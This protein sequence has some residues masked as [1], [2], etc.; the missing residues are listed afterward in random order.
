ML[1]ITSLAGSNLAYSMCAKQQPPMQNKAAA[2]ATASLLLHTSRSCLHLLLV[3]GCEDVHVVV[4]SVPHGD[5]QHCQHVG[6]V[7]REAVE[8]EPVELHAHEAGGAVHTQVGRVL[9][10]LILE[11][12]D[13]LGRGGLCVL[14]LQT[15]HGGI[16]ALLD[17]L[18]SYHK[19]NEVVG[20]R[21][22][23]PH[24]HGQHRELHVA[25]PRELGLLLCTEAAVAGY[26]L[27][28]E[29]AHDPGHDGGGQ[30]LEQ[31]RDLVEA[32]EHKAVACG[33]C[34]GCEDAHHQAEH[35]LVE[36][37]AEGQEA[38]VDDAQC[39]AHIAELQ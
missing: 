1:R 25:P 6:G 5:Q 31:G 2:A 38:E 3:A 28:G 33:N 11:P 15:E 34:G 30:V 35:H 7:Q 26:R 23:Q 24:R 37:G 4:G 18:L 17:A 9:D 20:R 32:V 14:G 29:P 36:R 16:A 22:G 13:E 12:Q 21:P 19:N 39:N 27:V 8:A 10:V